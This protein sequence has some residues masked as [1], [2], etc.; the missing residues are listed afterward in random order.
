MSNTI[1]FFLSSLFLEWCKIHEI[2]MTS[3]Q[4]DTTL[5]DSNTILTPPHSV[6]DNTH[7]LLTSQVIIHYS[8]ILA[9][10]YNDIFID[11]GG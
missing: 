8:M 9:R 5:T 3:E 1:F 11:V 4:T 6:A 2:S 7:Q 10:H